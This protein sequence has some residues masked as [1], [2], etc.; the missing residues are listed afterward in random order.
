MTHFSKKIKKVA[1][2]KILSK[3]E[4]RSVDLN[5]CTRLGSSLRGS[6]NP[7]CSLSDEDKIGI[8]KDFIASDSGV[9]KPDLLA[10]EFLF[11]GPVVGPLSKQEYLKAVGSFDL[12]TAFPDCRTNA[13]NFIVDGDDP[14]LVRFTT[15]CRKST[16]C[17]KC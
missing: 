11:E 3:K 10:E 9:S 5:Y 7:T 17:L 15:R 1:A 14:D 6:R 13:N 16:T 2:C 4:S 8:A 12:K